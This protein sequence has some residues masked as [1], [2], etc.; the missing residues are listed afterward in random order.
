MRH[1]VV[2]SCSLLPFQVTHPCEEDT[3]GCCQPFNSR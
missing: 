2:I 1:K 3:N